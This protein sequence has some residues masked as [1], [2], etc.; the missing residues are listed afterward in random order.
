LPALS[1]TTHVGGLESDVEITR[2]RFAVPHIFA[3]KEV[4]AAFGLGFVH[5]QDRLWQLELNRRLGSGQLAELF[6]REAL[7]EDRLFRTLQLRRI[8]AANLTALDYETQATLAAYARGVNAYLDSPGRR[9]PPEFTLFRVE[10]RRWQ[11]TDSLLILKVMS[12]ML[13]GNWGSELARLRLARRLTD[14]QVEQLLGGGKLANDTWR[15]WS[16]GLDSVASS[17]HDFVPF[18]RDAPIGSNNWA[19]DGSRSMSGKPLLANDPHLEL[20]APVMWYLAHLQAPGWSVIGA[21]LPGIPAVIVGRNERVAWAFTNTESDTEDLFIEQLDPNDPTR[22]LTPWGAEHFKVT[23]ETIAI[24]GEPEEVLTVRESRHGPILSDVKARAREAIPEDKVLA[25]SWMGQRTH[26]LTLQFSMKAAHARSSRELHEAARDFHSPQQNIVYADV[27]GNIGFVAAGLVPIRHP[28]ND[29]RGMVP[30]PGWLEKYD[31]IG[32]IPFEELPRGEPGATRL[33][34][35]NQDVQPPG[36]PYVLG[37]D[38]APPFRAER[39]AALVD[40]TPKHSVA[41]FQ[42]IQLDVWSRTAAELSPF[43]LKAAAQ[44]HTDEPLV[45]RLG[46]WNHEMRAELAEPLI[47]AAWLRELT[48]L[49]Y[50][51]ELGDMFSWQWSDSPQFVSGVLADRDGMSRWCDDVRT[52][53]SESCE[54]LASRALD[55]AFAY[56]K[57]H[58]GEDT[59]TWSWGRAHELRAESLPLSQLPLLGRLFDVRFPGSGDNE[60]VNVA[61][62]SVAADEPF[63]SRYGPGYRAIY[64]LGDLERSVFVTSTGQSG[65]FLSDYYRNLGMIWHAGR[66]IPMITD[67]T[68]IVA[69]A[70]GTLRLRPTP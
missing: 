64:D 30:A 37:S 24:K 23:R 17:L 56:L 40:L 10:P 49:I 5:A 57:R 33:V 41:S 18:P 25:L 11:P 69:D 55:L 42:R 35:A 12:W 29:L 32:E 34:T 43:L 26:D 28:E 59:S 53:G 2:D 1:G 45:A 58:H 22:Y 51:D 8:V 15:Q 13:S 27:E 67:R 50:A 21:T 7:D 36:Y 46:Q 60:T 20:T 63:V 44:A 48:R 16:Q 38:W 65:H 14:Q 4:D 39:I 19:V 54:A 52:A 3:K 70:L 6:G 9:L 47:F 31:W 66:Y 61:G 62:Y 68:R